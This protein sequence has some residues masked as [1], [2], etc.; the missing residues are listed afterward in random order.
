MEQVNSV[1]THISVAEMLASDL[2]QPAV[3]IS[4]SAFLEAFAT[5]IKKKIVC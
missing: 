1:V 4:L 2:V 5:K 3:V